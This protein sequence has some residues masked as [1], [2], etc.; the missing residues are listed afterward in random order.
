MCFLEMFKSLHSSVTVSLIM[1]S[2]VSSKFVPE[3]GLSLFGVG[4]RSHNVKIFPANAGQEVDELILAACM[5]S[6]A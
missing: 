1:V 3:L 6:P 5:S 4:P 2:I